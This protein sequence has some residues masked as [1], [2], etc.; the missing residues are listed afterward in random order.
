M[1]Q[2]RLSVN[3]LDF[4]AQVGNCAEV[5]GGVGDFDFAVEAAERLD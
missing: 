2:W 3:V 5:V 1:G 4:D